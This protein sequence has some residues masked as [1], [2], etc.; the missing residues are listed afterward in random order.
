MKNFEGEKNRGEFKMEQKCSFLF[1]S[2]SLVLVLV[3]YLSEWKR[4]Q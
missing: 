4:L 3:K 2:T 1:D